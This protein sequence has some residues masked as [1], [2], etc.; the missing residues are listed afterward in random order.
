MRP[1]GLP[2]PKQTNLGPGYRYEENRRVAKRLAIAFFCSSLYSS[3]FYG[4]PPAATSKLL[5][6][7]CQ[8]PVHNRTPSSVSFSRF[9]ELNLKKVDSGWIRLQ[10]T[11]EGWC[12][13]RISHTF[14]ANFFT[15]RTG[16]PPS[17]S[18]SKES[19]SRIRWRNSCSA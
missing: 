5:L 4:T 1:A 12:R 2:T 8:C 6:Q 11:G 18:R 13:V 15:A 3:S 17:T 10:H 19:M 9:E 14:L 7:L 16:G